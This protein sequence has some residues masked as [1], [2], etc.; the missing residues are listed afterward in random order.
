MGSNLKKEDEPS[1]AVHSF[2]GRYISSRHEEFD[3]EYK[4]QNGGQAES[5]GS[6]YQNTG[7]YNG[8]KHKRNKKIYAK[9]LKDHYGYTGNSPINAL[10]AVFA[11]QLKKFKKDKLT[12]YRAIITVNDPEALSETWNKYGVFESWGTKKH[13][14]D[15]YSAGVVSLNS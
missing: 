9:F 7:T 2:E 14:A 3:I 8:G 13:N 1:I 11:S 10:E 12:I 5:S 6:F 15:I 4:C